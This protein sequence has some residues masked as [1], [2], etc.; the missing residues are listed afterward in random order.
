[1]IGFADKKDSESIVGLWQEAF[2]DSREWVLMYLGENIDNVLVYRENG[3]VMGML[4]LLP[5]LYKGKNGFYVYG[6]ATGEKYR[7]K[8]VSTKL[9][10]YAKQL[11]NDKKADFLVLVPRNEGLFEFYSLRGF[12]RKYCVKTEIFAKEEL[13]KSADSTAFRKASPCEYFAVRKNSYDNLIEWDT[14]MLESI[15]K[16]ENG[17]FYVAEN[18]EGAFCYAYGDTLYIK[19]LCGQLTLA[20]KISKQYDCTRVAV[21]KKC[22]SDTPSCMIYPD[23]SDDVFFNIS[24]D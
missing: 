20:A 11:V 14:D 1:M 10:E 4:S 17:E 19:E 3:V 12:Y 2:G 18:G 6:V 23:F 24:I 8:G 13:E 9:L 21:T 22:D 7:S 15:R 5:V 16:F